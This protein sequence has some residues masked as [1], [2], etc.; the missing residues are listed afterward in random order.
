[1]KHL[2]R[3]LLLV[4]AAPAVALAVPPASTAPV[5]AA[6]PA[7]APAGGFSTGTPVKA[8]QP[9]DNVAKQ[10]ARWDTD[11]NGSLSLEEFRVGYLQA[12][13]NI[14]IAQ[15]RQQFVARDTDKSGYLEKGE[16]EALPLVKQEGAKAAPFAAVDK[17]GDGRLDFTEYAEL[18]TK[19]VRQNH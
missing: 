2:T 3:A 14:A 19:A 10:F 9:V 4:L 15:L 12:E 8:V 18:V 13:R 5:P 11:K 16:Y 7:A 6:A 1:M 17:N